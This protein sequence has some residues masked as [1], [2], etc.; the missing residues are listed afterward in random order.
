MSGALPVAFV[1]TDGG[2]QLARADVQHVAEDALSEEPLQ[3]S[4]RRLS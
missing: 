2:E 3:E 4:H 1:P